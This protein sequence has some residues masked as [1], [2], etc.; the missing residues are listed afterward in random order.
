M[1]NEL[2]ASLTEKLKCTQS[3]DDDN[4]KQEL[5]AIEIS[6]QTYIDKRFVQLQQHIDD[7]F[8]RLEEKLTKLDRNQD[9]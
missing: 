2:K 3:R 1:H 7:R 9:Q 8:D 4:I 6:L 5:N